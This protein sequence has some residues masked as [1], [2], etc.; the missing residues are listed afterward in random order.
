ML[1]AIVLFAYLASPI[2]LSNINAYYGTVDLNMLT[3]DI[4]T[5]SQVLLKRLHSSTFTFLFNHCDIL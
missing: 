5:Q 4:T 3:K 1:G 2:K